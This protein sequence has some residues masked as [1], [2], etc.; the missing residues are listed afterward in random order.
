MSGSRIYQHYEK[1][2][3]MTSG[4]P[5]AES[6]SPWLK[7]LNQHHSPVGDAFFARSN[8]ERIQRWIAE[9]VKR[10][11]G[12]TIDASAQS[13]EDLGQIMREIYYAEANSSPM[14]VADEVRRLDFEVLSEAVPIVS[15]NLVG[16]LAYLRDASRI[17]T[18]LPRGVA[19]NIKASRQLQPKPWL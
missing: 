14:S 12:Y 19:T 15:G 18:P 5:H 16:Y 1:P 2:F 6:L 4:D 3:P 11:T 13:T 9:A 7:S 8:V 10:L 17:A